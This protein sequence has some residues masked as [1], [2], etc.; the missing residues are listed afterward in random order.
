MLLCFK[1]GLTLNYNMYKGRVKYIAPNKKEP[2]FGSFFI[3]RVRFC[4][5]SM[6]WQKRKHVSLYRSQRCE[7]FEG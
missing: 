6:L 1:V 2:N 5:I 4:L 3:I 7:L